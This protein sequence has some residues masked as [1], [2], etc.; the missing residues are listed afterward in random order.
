MRAECSYISIVFVQLCKR[1]LCSHKGGQFLHQ[2][3]DSHYVKDSAAYG[4]FLVG[5]SVGRFVIHA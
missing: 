3:G 4:W 2:V 1:P 5:R